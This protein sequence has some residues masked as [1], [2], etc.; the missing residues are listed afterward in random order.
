MPNS[1]YRTRNEVRVEKVAVLTGFQIYWSSLQT[2]CKRV[3]GISR[4][5]LGPDA[6]SGH[7][8]KVQSALKRR[9]IGSTGAISEPD[10]GYHTTFL[11]WTAARGFGATSLSPAVFRRDV[12]VV[13]VREERCADVPNVLTVARRLILQLSGWTEVAI[14]IPT[15]VA[16]PAKVLP[17]D[18]DTI[19]WLPRRSTPHCRHKGHRYQACGRSET[20]FE[21][22]LQ[23]PQGLG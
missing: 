2:T 10:R 9:R 8:A 6:L 16:R 5:L 13:C 21:N 19:K 12:A 1:P 23:Q 11:I 20:D 17:C 18:A 3:W 14:G 4:R 15:F 7:I 22:P